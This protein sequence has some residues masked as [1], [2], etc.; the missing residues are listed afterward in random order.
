MVFYCCF[1]NLL[2]ILQSH[3][4][5]AAYEGYEESPEVP[6]LK[7]F[8]PTGYLWS[9]ISIETLFEHFFSVILGV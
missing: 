8:S 3:K 9:L 7:H 5:M 4:Q 6:S 2:A 1:Q